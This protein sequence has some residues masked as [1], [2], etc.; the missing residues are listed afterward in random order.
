[1]SSSTQ[2]I[3]SVH[4]YFDQ[5]LD[6][7]F[8]KDQPEDGRVL[9]PID[10]DTHDQGPHTESLIIDSLATRYQTI[11]PSG[12]AKS[13]ILDFTALAS[14]I[15]VDGI[16]Y[17]ADGSW[18][19]R[20]LDGSVTWCLDKPSDAVKL[21]YLVFSDHDLDPGVLTRT[22]SWEAKVQ[23]CGAGEGTL[24]YSYLDTGPLRGQPGSSSAVDATVQALLK[25]ND[26]TTG[27]QA[28]FLNAGS[29]YGVTTAWKTIL[30]RA[31]TGAL[32]DLE[33]RWDARGARSTSTASPQEA[34]S[35]MTASAGSASASICPCT[36]SSTRA[37]AALGSGHSSDEVRI[38]TPDCEGIEA[39]STGD[40]QRFR[41]RLSF[42]G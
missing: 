6:D 28:E 24:T 16:V 23:G 8:P 37:G 7:Q 4:H 27:S 26:F 29:T 30:H 14:D 12:D 5:S 19:R 40:V 36:K 31:S 41:L 10:L 33:W 39:G 20:K 15:D 17:M 22:W 2:G 21:V 34:T 18:Q 38:Q 9:D 3:R 35:T 32:L 11:S 13:I 1:M 42:P 25:L